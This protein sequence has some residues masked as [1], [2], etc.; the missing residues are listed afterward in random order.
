MKKIKWFL[1]TAML[2]GLLFAFLPFQSAEAAESN[3]YEY[4]VLEDGTASV[5]KYNGTNSAVVIPEQLDGYTISSIGSSAFARNNGIKTVELPAQLK[6]IDPFA[7]YQCELLEQIDFPEGLTNIR[8]NAFDSC[9]S[10]KTIEIPESL[11]AL[12][13]DAFAGCESLSAIQVASGNKYFASEKNVLFSKDKTELIFYPA[14]LSQNIYA[15]PESVTTISSGA[16]LDA[17]N[18]DR[19]YI[20]KSVT[21]IEESAFDNANQ[22]IVICGESGSAAEQYALDNGM[23]FANE[24]YVQIESVTMSQDVVRME[25]ANEAVTL[26][27]AFTPENATDKSI[28]WT[29]N[30]PSVATVDADGK[31][32]AKGNGLTIIIAQCGSK[33]AY[34]QVY[35][36][37]PDPEPT[38]TPDPAPV[39]KASFDKQ[40][41]QLY[42]TAKIKAKLVSNMTGDTFVSVRSSSTAI[43]TIAKDGT[44]TG[45]KG[46]TATITATTKSG[47]TISATVKVVT[48]SV[49]LNLSSIPLQLKKSTTAVKVKTKLSTDSV[50]KWSSSNSKI[51]TVN[52]K[53]GKITAK[54][55]GKAYIIVK[56]KSG[57]TAK[58][59]VTVQKSPVK[60][61][62]LTVNQTKVT[63][64]L[65][66]GK[67]TFQIAAVKTPVTS[68]EK[69]TYKSS[70]TKVATVSSK[71]KIT[72][73]KAGKA[74][75]TVK[76]GNKVK[77]ITVTVKK[78]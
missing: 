63:L 38:P 20:P 19:I 27:V 25:K 10:L 44:I 47:K 22:N 17:K 31:V 5:T 76:A 35:V 64:K 11:S 14:A 69:V 29:S 54:K 37:I 55:T 1:L 72:A 49:K 53:T 48:P 12:G 8:Y 34:C 15:V 59:K 23:K 61:T 78:K 21:T 75:I 39:Y 70:N 28:K 73:K 4:E 33:Y 24:Q 32:I 40:T 65:K 26:K 68:L 56:M 9:K 50:S 13:E 41:Y 18:I 60:T 16:F 67:K 62:K 57:A 66:G 2:A 77:K 58:C 6:R 43:A 3:G 71:G 30:N 42:A 46:G 36:S 45:V 74:T 52:A 7:F 51:I